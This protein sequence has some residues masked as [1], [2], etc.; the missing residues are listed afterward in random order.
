MSHTTDDETD[1]DGSSMGMD[2][3]LDL[4]SHDIIDIGLGVDEI[5]STE[6]NVNLFNY[7]NFSSYSNKGRSNV[8]PNSSLNSIDFDTD[9][10]NEKEKRGSR[11]DILDGR[12]STQLFQDDTMFLNQCNNNVHFTQFDCNKLE[13]DFSDELSDNTDSDFLSLDDGFVNNLLEM[14]A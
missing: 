6:L 11:S 12:A 2:A 13:Q 8:L 4:A 7:S 5:L 1:A 3:A 9:K 10:F 14:F